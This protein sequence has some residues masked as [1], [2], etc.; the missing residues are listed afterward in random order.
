MQAE[1]E[2]VARA[3]ETQQ[4]RERAAA[5]RS[6]ASLHSRTLVNI[7]ASS[8]GTAVDW[9]M[10]VEQASVRPFRV[11]GFRRASAK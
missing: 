8:D 1:I 9:P 3:A 11:K 5:K 10:D 6:K 7:T 4:S 2:R